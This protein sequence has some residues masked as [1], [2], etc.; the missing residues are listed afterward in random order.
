MITFAA[1]IRV[2]GTLKSIAMQVSKVGLRE[3]SKDTLD[4]FLETLEWYFTG[5]GSTFLSPRMQ[6]FSHMTLNLVKFEKLHPEILD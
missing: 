2:N 6:L 3:T 5:G 4:T 1:C